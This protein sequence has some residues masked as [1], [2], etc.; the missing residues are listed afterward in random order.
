MAIIAADSIESYTETVLGDM[1]LKVADELGV[2][3]GAVTIVAEPASV[4]LT[5]TVSYTDAAS[6]SEG[7][8][9]LAA[10]SGSTSAASALLS[11]S[12]FGVHVEAIAIAPTIIDSSVAPVCVPCLDGADCSGTGSTLFNL[13]LEPGRW[14]TSATSL[15]I[16]TCIAASSC[17]GDSTGSRY[18]AEGSEGPLCAVCSDDYRRV[19]SGACES[20]S[21]VAVADLLPSVVFFLVLGLI[22][23]SCVVVRL[24]A[25]RRKARGEPAPPKLKYKETPKTRVQRVLSQMTVKLKIAIASQQVMQGLG[26]GDHVEARIHD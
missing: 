25:R 5:I 24:A 6:A 17:V 14:R 23:A 16:E 26:P 15:V 3:V 22:V 11:T 20:C 19:M 18:C 12:S 2:P 7:Q 4:K 10:A 8:A 9:A 1:N 21:V 13:K